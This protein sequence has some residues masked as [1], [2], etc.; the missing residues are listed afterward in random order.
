MQFPEAWHNSLQ[1]PKTI[2]TGPKTYLGEDQN[3]MLCLMQSD[4]QLVKNNQL[5][6][7]QNDPF[8]FTVVANSKIPSIPMVCTF[9][10]ERVV[11][12]FL[13]LHNNV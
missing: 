8:Q 11:A 2:Q 13:Q 9:K 6:T 4:K 7:T 12:A 10:Q 5:P 1:L 3:S